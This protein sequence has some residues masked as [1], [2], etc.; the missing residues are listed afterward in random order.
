MKGGITVMNNSYY[1]YADNSKT[2]YTVFGNLIF[3]LR[4]TWQC[5]KL[6]M[7]CMVSGAVPE[8]IGSYLGTILPSIL[9]SGL[10]AQ[11]TL[12]VLL[13]S[14]GAAGMG[15]IVCQMLTYLCTA[16]RTEANK[17]YSY[18]LTERF[19]RKMPDIDYELLESASYQE[20]YSN[21]WSSANNGQGFAW[22]ISFVPDMLSGLLGV[23]IFGWILGS[24]NLLILLLVFLCV[25]GNLYLLGVARKVHKKYYGKISRYAKGEEYITHITMDSASGKDIR[26]Y[27]ML[28]F[29]LKKYDE[30]LEKIGGYY[31]KIH[32]WYMFRNL[33]GAVFSFLR[34]AAAYLFLIRE[35]VS[36]RIPAAEFVFLL[37]V[38]DNLAAY[39]EKLLRVIMIWNSL[40]ASVGYFRQFLET[41]SASRTEPA[42][43]DEKMEEIRAHGIE[44][45][46]ENVS[47]TYEGAG[48]PTIRN[49]NLKIK[50]GEKLALIGLNGAGKTTL[51]KLICGLYT[52]DEGKILVNGID[53]EQFTK[54]QY[55]SLFSVMFQDSY[56]LP[57]TLDENLTS[58]VQPDEK[59]LEFALKQSGF[60]EKYQSVPGKGQVML[61]KKLNESAIDFSGGEKQKL[62]FAR[63]IY[64]D[65]SFVILDEPTAALDPIAENELYSNFKDSVGERTV[66]YISHRLSST[67]FCDRIVL[68][69]GGKIVEEGVHGDL[70]ARGGRYAALYEMQSKYYKEEIE[71]KRKQKIMEEGGVY[72]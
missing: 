40:D 24:R 33:S 64:R 20:I 65:S 57:L 22:G 16:Y 52:P 18:H 58:S 56:F 51:V 35:L 48:E 50:Q 10:S 38:I 23:A 19:L 67:R 53:R 69:E 32:N 62:I 1:I 55:I 5:N 29:I 61:V 44:I 14:L 41:E 72:A 42:I 28:D 71:R 36:G 60:Y 21:V 68:I 31:G 54:E 46:L 49:F 2:K 27:R 15:Y 12:D 9:V 25:G 6:L 70:M 34:D 45:K 47:Y 39:F 37:G 13:I 26:I 30:N 11:E 59:R 3:F 7:L 66:L 63:A 8:M 43:S 17:F 4:E